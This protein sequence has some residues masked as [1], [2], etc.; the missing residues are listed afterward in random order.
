M[1]RIEGLKINW[2]KLAS[3][4][5]DKGMSIKT[6]RQQTGISYKTLQSIRK[7]C[8]VRIETVGKLAR[9][10]DVKSIELIESDEE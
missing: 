8:F 1:K 4:F 9:L 7:G 2:I 3:M 5:A 10:L 6:V